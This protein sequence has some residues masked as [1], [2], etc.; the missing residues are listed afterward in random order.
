MKLL[1]LSALSACEKQLENYTVG[2]RSPTKLQDFLFKDYY[3][4]TVMCLKD[5]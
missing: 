3:V 1:L 4:Y 2:Y 5:D